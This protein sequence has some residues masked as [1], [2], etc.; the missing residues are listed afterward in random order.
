[1]TRGRAA[2]GLLLLGLAQMSADLADLQALKVVALATG[3]S[4][5]PRVF[6][7]FGGFE[8]YSTR[9]TLAW[10]DGSGRVRSLVLT[11]EVYARLEGPYNRRNAYGAA[12]AAGPVLAADSRTAP[13]LRAVMAYGLCGDAPV[14][15]EL[16]IDPSAVND[17]R[18]R[19]EPVAGTK[20]DPAL[21]REI[22]AACP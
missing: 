2:I 14:L 3:A 10:T 5:A 20:M 15:R 1:M 7:S 6:T 4:P 11:P 21:P 17:L 12:L 16:G 13:M 22:E 8:P 18:I 9:F 19:Y